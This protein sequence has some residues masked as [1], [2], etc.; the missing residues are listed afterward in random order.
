M[1]P[2][3]SEVQL[4]QRLARKVAGHDDHELV[5]V[6]AG[7]V[8]ALLAKI[9]SLMPAPAFVI[10][11]EKRERMMLDAIERYG[12]VLDRLALDDVAPDGGARASQAER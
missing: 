2:V 10:P 4:E 12:P 7:D 5:I 3:I 8:R 9:A 6:R 11:P 1:R